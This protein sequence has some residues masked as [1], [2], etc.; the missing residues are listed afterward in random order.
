[1]SSAKTFSCNFTYYDCIS[2]DV[3]YGLGTYNS[4][5]LTRNS[6]ETKIK[7]TV[8]PNLNQ[9]DISY[10]FLTILFPFLF[11]IGPRILFA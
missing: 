1:M 9:A 11:N 4:A 3:L 10:F 8:K 5:L 7:L 6:I 2:V